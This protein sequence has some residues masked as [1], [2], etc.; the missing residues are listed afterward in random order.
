MT[1]CQSQAQLPTEGD[2]LSFVS[3]KKPTPAAQLALAHKHLARVQSAW[4][5]PTNW[6]DLMLYG[7]Y[8]VEAAIRAAALQLSHDLKKTHWDKAEYA[9]RL[10]TEYKLPDVSELVA[11]L[12]RGRKAVGYGDDEIPDE[13]GDAE[14]IAI[15]IEE[16]IDAVEAFIESCP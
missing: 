11:D 4:T 7:M 14:V 5:E 15:R 13:L 2:T 1:V 10:T 12:N 6:D 3:A 9:K 16:F 8:A